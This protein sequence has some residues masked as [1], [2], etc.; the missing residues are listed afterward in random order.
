MIGRTPPF[1]ETTRQ[2]WMNPPEVP[3]GK[4]PLEETPS[5]QEQLEQEEDPEE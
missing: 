2:I 3:R 4:D 5:L 1:P